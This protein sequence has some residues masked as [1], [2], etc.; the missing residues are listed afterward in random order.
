MRSRF[1]TLAVATLT[2]LVMS[3][4]ATAQDKPQKM[5]VGVI[6]FRAENDVGLENSGR[7]VA[8][9][10][11][12][13]IVR[14]GRF[15]VSERLSLE[16]VLLEQDLGMTGVLSDATAAQAGK[17][18]GVQGIVTGSIMKIGSTISVTGR[19]IATE[20]GEVLKT[21]VVRAA[22]LDDLPHEIEVL[23]NALSEVSRAEFEIGQ[24]L[25]K[26]SLSYLA[27]G[28]GLA[29]GASENSGTIG[30]VDKNFTTFGIAVSMSFTTRRY[31]LWLQ[32][33]PIG[34]IKNLQ[35]GASFDFNQFF[36]P[37]VEVGFIAD[38]AINSVFVN[39][40]ALGIKFQPRHEFAMKVLFGGS[41]SGLLWQW[42]NDN[43][44]G[45]KEEVEGYFQL[46]PPST[47]SV[48]ALYRLGQRTLILAKIAG[49]SLNEYTL[50]N[51]EDVL[52]NFYASSVL[53]LTIQT[54]LPIS[55]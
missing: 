3:R 32:G 39:Y 47:Y 30:W 22:S 40:F 25:A 23:A 50:A 24:D 17:L 42:S 48:E 46:V 7:I 19:I 2:L 10:V 49:T 44:G 43:P 53:L 37:A 16:S 26:R 13:E 35:V 28:G 51:H 36:G 45:P 20:T 4:V 21:S 31:S 14:V 33:I 1:L 27:I 52:G 54:E 12:S 38:D 55:F 18:H 15:D 6:E 9:W 34:A 8:E 5:R 11:A 41:T 29:L